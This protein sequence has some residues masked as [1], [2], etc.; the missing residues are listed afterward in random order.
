MGRKKSSTETHRQPATGTCSLPVT[1]K[2]NDK[3]VVV[4]PDCVI[5]R[6]YNGDDVRWEAR[7]PAERICGV[8]LKPAGRFGIG[9][10]LLGVADADGVCKGTKLDNIWDEN[11]IYFGHHAQEQFRAARDA[12]E[13]LMRH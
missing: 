7:V 13:Q 6:A 3:E 12:V 5:V 11:T 1:A 2:G 10:L 8:E 9:Y 4:C